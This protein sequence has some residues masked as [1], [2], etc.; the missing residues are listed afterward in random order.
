VNNRYLR[1]TKVGNPIITSNNNNVT[2]ITSLD[3]KGIRITKR[4]NNKKI[5]S[6]II[7]K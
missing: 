2:Y 3:S 5:K 1:K 7:L 6:P 4:E